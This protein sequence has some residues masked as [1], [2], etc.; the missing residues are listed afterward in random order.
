MSLRTC[1]LKICHQSAEVGN[2]TVYSETCKISCLHNFWWSIYSDDKLKTR[3]SYE[4]CLPHSR[5]CCCLGPIHL[6]G[7]QWLVVLVCQLLPYFMGLGIDLVLCGTGLCSIQV[8][9][10]GVVPFVSTLYL[11]LG[12]VPLQGFLCIVPCEFVL[13]VC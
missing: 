11:L 9:F 1:W 8:S 3:S 2:L 10:L 13:F 7:L 4:T 12:S 5:V 6:F